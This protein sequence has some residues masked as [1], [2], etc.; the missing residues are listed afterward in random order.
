MAIGSALNF[1]RS[2]LTSPMNSLAERLT[3][4]GT[5]MVD[6]A[7]KDDLLKE[8]RDIQAVQDA[9]QVKADLLAT[10]GT[11]EYEAAQRA[12]AQ[13][14]LEVNK[15]DP[16]YELKQQ[17]YKASIPGTP[18]Y[19][20]ALKIKAD[21]NRTIN[22]NDPDYVR[23]Q[24][25]KNLQLQEIINN[26]ANK[27]AS[28]ESFTA[29]IENLYNLPQTKEIFDEKANAEY[30]DAKKLLES[31]I[32]HQKAILSKNFSPETNAGITKQI[33]I[34]EDRLNS[35]VAPVTEQKPL[36]KEEYIKNIVDSQK[37]I[38]FNTPEEAQK[39]QTL[40]KNRIDILYP[41]KTKSITPYQAYQ[42]QQ[43]E[44]E[45]KSKEATAMSL[46]KATF[47]KEKLNKILK[48][49]NNITPEALTKLAEKNMNKKY[50]STSI[51]DAIS[52]IVTDG[53]TDSNRNITANKDKLE[54]ILR[55]KFKGNKADMVQ[56]IKGEYAVQGTGAFKNWLGNS[57]IGDALDNFID[58]Y[59][60]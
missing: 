41:E 56:A 21:I 57:P 47:S 45:A 16:N 49:N 34:Y 12:K 2:N 26:N 1:S 42:V 28:K 50:S 44:K 36:S 54:K 32:E 30:L 53:D 4:F 43:K 24:K 9:R 18:E 58:K 17:S 27:K 59:D 55:E 51:T 52:D 20:N 31:Q 19:E 10:P 29:N 23:N 46:A 25:L 39:Y 8:A 14:Q 3:K 22:L 60:K 37:N 40:L 6:Q 38:K 48:N 35:L 33:K 7:N 13:M 5:N 11:P 15:L